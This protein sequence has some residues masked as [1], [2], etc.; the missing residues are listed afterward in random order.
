MKRLL[1]TSAIITTVLLSACQSADY[2]QHQTGFYPITQEGKIWF[3]DQTI[4]SIRLI[5]LDN[6]TAH[7]MEDWITMTPTSGK[8]AYNTTRLDFSFSTNTTGKN[9]TNWIVVNGYDDIRMRA[10]QKFHLNIE[11]PTL[12]VEENGNYKCEE[13]ITAKT[14]H[15]PIFF[16][17]YSDKATISCNDDWILMPDTIFAAG[18]HDFKLPCLPNKLKQ[19]RSTTITITSAGINT[20]VKLIQEGKKE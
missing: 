13:K 6:W 3:A 18:K 9:R 7:C 8:G 17:T 1:T 15:F 11:H 16:T 12:N 5:S 2:E 14:T 19:E 10:E 20:K 4:D